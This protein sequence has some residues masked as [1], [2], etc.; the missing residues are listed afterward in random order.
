[1]IRK[2]GPVFRKDH[3]Q[4]KDNE[5]GPLQLNVI[6]PV[7]MGCALLWWIGRRM[8]WTRRLVVTAITL[9]VIICVLLFERGGF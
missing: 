9:V 7:I 5:G 2:S 3:A 8:S 1:M 4:T 6:V